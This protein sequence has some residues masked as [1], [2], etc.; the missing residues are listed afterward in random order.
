MKP[1]LKRKVFK[2]WFRPKDDIITKEK[3]NKIVIKFG[4]VRW[5]PKEDC[6]VKITLEWEQ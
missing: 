2:G 6:R 1:K 4:Q 5:Y 3:P